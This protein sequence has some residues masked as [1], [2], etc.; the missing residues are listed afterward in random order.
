LLQELTLNYEQ[1]QQLAAML[2]D[3][4]RSRESLLQEADALNE[5]NAQLDQQLAAYH[6]A[7]DSLNAGIENYTRNCAGQPLT[8]EALA[9]CE[10]QRIRLE[11]RNTQLT[12]QFEQLNAREARYSARVEEIN[13]REN[14]RALAAQQIISR[15][16]QAEQAFDRVVAEFVR[17]NFESQACVALEPEDT[18][19]CMRT[20]WEEP[21]L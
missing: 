4:T 15:Y 14:E 6:T 12:S 18:Y 10:T 2:E 21:G 5:E 17:I 8:N 11:D 1:L 16:Q 19:P 9:A 13:R 20:F 7:L 3:N